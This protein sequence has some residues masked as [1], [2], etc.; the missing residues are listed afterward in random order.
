M[1]TLLSSVAKTDVVIIP[2]TPNVGD[3]T[4]ITTVTTGNPVTTDN[5]I[6]HDF[7]DG[8][9]NGSMFPDSSDINENIYLTGKD[10]AYAETTIKSEDYVSIEE[11]R[12]GFTSNFNADIRWWNPT[13]STVTM[14]QIASNGVDTTTQS[15][16]FEDTTNHNY[17]F[18]NYGNTLIMNADPDMTHGT[19]TAG[20]SFDIQG[21]KNYNGGHA[22]VDVKDPTLTIDYTALSATTV[23]TVEY[24]WQKNPPTCPG[25]DEIDIVEDIIDDIDTIIYDI[26]D[27]F[28]E[29]EPIPIDIEY[30]FNPDLFEEEEFDI[31]DDYMIADEFFFE[32][33]YYQDDFYEDIELAYV[34]ETDIDM[35]MDVDWNDSNVELF[36]DLPLVEEAVIDDI[37]MEEEMFVE[38]FTEEMQEE[39]I[40]EVYEEFVI[41]TEP[42]PMPE[43][44]PEPVEE[45][46]M[47]E[48]EIIEE[49]PI[50]EEIIDE[51]VAEQPSSE[52]VIADEPAPTTEIAEQEE[53][54]EEPAQEPN[55]DVEVDLDI[56]VAAIEKAIQNKVSNEM[57]R[58]SLTLDVINE[59]VSRE[60]T[61][62]QADISSYF[63]TNAALFD[64]RQLPGGDPMFF[65]QVSLAS[66]DKTIY[67]TQAN[68]VGTDPLV[69]HQ[70]KMIEAK[71]KTS[72]AYRKLME[73]INARSNQ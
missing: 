17:Q 9:W 62:K 18:N 21:N 6:S 59:V 35:D 24:C 43:P 55:A 32:D 33:D 44:E 60:M 23:T 4:T 50:E 31:Q 29:P 38:E 40:E 10:G 22:G 69:Q 47:V 1:A 7:I 25:Q 14:Y 11:L 2:D 51:E 61:A 45:V 73:K 58:V 68:I 46:A 56:K 41:E 65:M 36:D 49:E 27:D 30:S 64:T 63:D 52:E 66:Y 28:F 39:F 57:Q 37:V 8:T 70:I 3:T 71:K 20:F 42:E 67:A 72:D 16:T 12:L 19:L 13:E 5:L 54:V 48:E 15:T 26:P 34:P 53:V